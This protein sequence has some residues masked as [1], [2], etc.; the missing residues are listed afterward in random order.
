[1]RNFNNLKQVY[2]IVWYIFFNYFV[3]SFCV[4]V[5]KGKTRNTSLGEIDSLVFPLKLHFSFGYPQ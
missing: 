5:W 1:M 4:I 3:K 2:M